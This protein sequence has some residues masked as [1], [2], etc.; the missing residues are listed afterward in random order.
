MDISR[1]TPTFLLEEQTLNRIAPQSGGKVYYLRAARIE[2]GTNRM[3]DVQIFDV[4]DP[5]HP[6]HRLRR[7]RA[8]RRSAATART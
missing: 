8:R 5:G 1:K 2:P 6:A 4:S 7:L 3:W